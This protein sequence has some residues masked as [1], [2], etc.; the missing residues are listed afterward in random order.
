M[1][2]LM[3]ILALSFL[4]ATPALAT[5]IAQEQAKL[6]QTDK[7]QESLTEDTRSLLEELNPLNTGDLRTEATGIIQKALTKA[8]EPL[9]AAIK[10]CVCILLI[11]LLGSTVSSLELAG[12]AVS[13]CTCV[14][15][16]ACFLGDLTGM[17][18]S[19]I[20]AIEE[21]TTFSRALLPVMAG[22]L[23][24]SGAGTSS[25]ALYSCSM[26]ALQIMLSVLKNVLL[27]ILYAYIAIAG[28]GHCLG[29]NALDRFGK[30]LCSIMKN[31]LR[32]LLF[33]FS[34]LLSLTGI[35]SGQ[36]DALTLK[37]TKATVSSTVPVVGNMISDATETILVSAKLLANSV[38]VFGMLAVLAI[39]VIPFLQMG[40]RYLLLQITGALAA[41]VG[42]G[43]SLRLLDT[44]STAMGYLFAMTCVCG[45]LTFISCICFMKVSVF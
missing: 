31:S 38:G 34:G 37:A 23:A 27:P 44:L 3:I 35:I 1:K 15:I 45:L 39:L 16:L 7:I 8:Q 20:T 14:G 17:L 6:L 5:D 30:V 10:T 11:I 41:V 26:M 18:Q 19:G 32:F 25:A 40:I 12:R 33:A 21:L 29:T 4:L 28:A 43:E 9:S 36:A 22:A 24:A 2:R 42:E 13:L